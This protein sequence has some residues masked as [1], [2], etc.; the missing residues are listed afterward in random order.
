MRKIGVWCLAIIAAVVLAACAGKQIPEAYR[1]PEIEKA[2]QTKEI[3]NYL[4]ALR[5]QY[6]KLRQAGTLDRADFRRA[7]VSDTQATKL[8]NEYVE[9]VR[10]GKDTQAH[11]VA[12]S[13]FISTLEAVI[14]EVI[15]ELP[16]TRPKALAQ[17]LLVHQ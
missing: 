4:D 3:A 11:W 5:G 15:K 2:V 6:L 12:I 16:Q 9:L 17:G 14:L 8:W 7:V 1:T 13:S 10:A